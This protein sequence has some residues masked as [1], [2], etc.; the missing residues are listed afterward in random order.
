MC[1]LFGLAACVVAPLYLF[2]VM[3]MT[4]L[5]ARR[6]PG[7]L[8]EFPGALG[9]PVARALSIASLVLLWPFWLFAL[10][11]VQWRERRRCPW[12]ECGGWDW[13][14]SRVPA[15]AR[16]L[17]TVEQCPHQQAVESPA[18]CERTVKEAPWRDWFIG[19]SAAL[20]ATTL[21][22]LASLPVPGPG[23]VAVY[24]AVIATTAFPLT[25]LAEEFIDRI[26]WRRATQQ[27]VWSDRQ[28]WLATNPTE[29][30]LGEKP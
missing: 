24:L 23:F 1:F 10:G 25:V 2:G 14:A 27:V 4:Y 29:W 30:R 20:T 12:G 13:R 3:A 22:A 19:L 17:I 9:G 5:T 8:R 15:G 7:W 18:A 21:G 28:R 16:A 11:C 6:L 26:S